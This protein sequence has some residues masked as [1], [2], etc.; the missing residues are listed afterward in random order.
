MASFF[1]KTLLLLRKLFLVV[2]VYVSVVSLLFY[3]I[4]K[5][6]P[7]ISYDPIQKNRENIY[8]VLSDKKLAPPRKEKS[9]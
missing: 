8:K 4:N 1:K 5:D 2:A 7:K 6:K 9:V 3:F